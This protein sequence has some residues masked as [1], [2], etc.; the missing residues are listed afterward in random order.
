MSSAYRRLLINFPPSLN[1]PE[2]PCRA[3]LHHYTLLRWWTDTWWTSYTYVIFFSEAE[4][5]RHVLTAACCCLCRFCTSWTKFPIHNM[6]SHS[7]TCLIMSELDLTWLKPLRSQW[8]TGHRPNVAIL[9]CLMQ[10]LPLVASSS[11]CPV[12]L[13]PGFVSMCSSVSS[14][15]MSIWLP[16]LW[17]FWYTCSI[18]LQCMDAVYIQCIHAVYIQCIHVVYIQCIL[19]VHTLLRDPVY[20]QCMDAVYIQCIHVVYIQ[21][22]LVVHTLLRDPVNDE[23]K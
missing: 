2:N 19:V 21:C 18:P 8:S 16:V 3:F 15:T 5:R 17:L 22:I 1:P 10:Q 6:V 13:C 14:L 9:I 20:I 23:K 4:P 7:W 12:F 11:C